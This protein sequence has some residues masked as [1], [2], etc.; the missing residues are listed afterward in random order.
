[1]KGIYSGQLFMN[2]EIIYMTPQAEN[3]KETLCFHFICNIEDAL[4]NMP[5]NQKH[6]LSFSK[7]DSTYL[8]Y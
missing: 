4:Q 6:G 8:S 7:T 3:N 5:E 2:L 1:M